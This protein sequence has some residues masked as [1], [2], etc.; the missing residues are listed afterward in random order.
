MPAVL[1][2]ADFLFEKRLNDFIYQIVADFSDGKPS[3][4]FCSSR[5]GT[6]E[7]ADHLAGDAAKAAG[8]RQRGSIAATGSTFVRDAAHAQ[9]LATAAHSLQSVALQKCVRLGVG[10]HH[11]AMEPQERSVIESLFIVQD[12][13]VG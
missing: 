3:L 12:L 7:T 13:M 5:K 10:F 2:H 9:R 11:A 1:C 4:V 6:S 8:M